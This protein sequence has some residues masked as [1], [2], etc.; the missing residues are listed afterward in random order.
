MNTKTVFQLE[1]V[2]VEFER[3]SLS[4]RSLRSAIG[5]KLNGHKTEKIV[6]LKKISLNIQEGEHIGIIGKNGAGKST[7]LRVLTK[8]I[9]PFEGKVYLDNSKHIVPLLE[10][11]IGFQPDLSGRENCFVAGMLMGYSKKEIEDKIDSITEFAELQKFIDEPVRNY[12]SGMYA[13]LAFALATDIDPQVLLVD[14]IFGVGDEFFMKKCMMRMRELMDRG[15]TSIY[16]S[17][18]LD[19]LISECNRLIWIENGEIIMDGNSTTVA[20]SYRN[21]DVSLRLVSTN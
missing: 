10:L 1:N 11:G 8:V 12:S 7:L 18:N 13:R 14:E 9:I 19:F 17:H 15:L 2:S 16:I 20:S 5:R 6:A 4:Q 3:H 21:Q